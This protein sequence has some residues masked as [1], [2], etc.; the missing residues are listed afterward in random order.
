MNH[1]KH[2]RIDY[3]LNGSFKSFYISAEFMDNTEAWHHASVDAGIGRI[4][5]YRLERVPRVSRP[6]A[7]HFGISDVEW[8]QS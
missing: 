1:S 4:P 2:Y 8:A 6:Y 3:L 5:K 7:E